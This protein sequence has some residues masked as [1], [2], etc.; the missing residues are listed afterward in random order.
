MVRS[1]TIQSKPGDPGELDLPTTGT[2]IQ[3]STL[4][5]ERERRASQQLWH[6]YMHSLAFIFQLS[7][8]T[9]GR[10]KSDN[11]ESVKVSKILTQ[12]PVNTLWYKSANLQLNVL[13]SHL[14]VQRTVTLIRRYRRVIQHDLIFRK[15]Q[16]LTPPRLPPTDP[17]ANL[18]DDVLIRTCC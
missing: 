6:L 10:N 17:A 3:H 4:D 13:Y 18:P 7:V 9:D 5:P 14:G 11:V 8:R 15:K 12:S 16:S 1:L 2:G